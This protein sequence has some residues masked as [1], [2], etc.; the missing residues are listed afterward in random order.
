M[1]E[2][3]TTGGWI[4]YRA[5][6]FKTPDFFNGVCVWVFVHIKKEISKSKTKKHFSFLVS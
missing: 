1:T 3:I 6:Q 4:S 5:I 2:V